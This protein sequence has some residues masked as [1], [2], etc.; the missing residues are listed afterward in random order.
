ML[1]EECP[2]QKKP[3]EGK[4]EQAENWLNKGMCRSPERG[5]RKYHG[6][7]SE[8]LL[9]HEKRVSQTAR[10]EKQEWRVVGVPMQLWKKAK[11]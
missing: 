3:E 4:K 7:M 2:E 10:K 1:P 9:I 11:R 5:G 8:R 6:P